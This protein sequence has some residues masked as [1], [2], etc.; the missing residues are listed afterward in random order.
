[1]KTS[2]NE[3][4]K[5]IKELLDTA[6]SAA[7]EAGDIR[8]VWD[9]HTPPS[10]H[11]ERFIN[12]LTARSS[13]ASS[14]KSSQKNRP[15]LI[16]LNKA[17]WMAAASVAIVVSVLFWNQPTLKARDL[18]DVSEKMAQVEEFFRETLAHEVILLEEQKNEKTKVIIERAFD[19]MKKIEADYEKL[20]HDLATSGSDT[21]VI[22]AMIENFQKRI[23]VLEYVITQ[24]EQMDAS[25]SSL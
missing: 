25:T 13:N 15:I 6:R 17:W 19:D 7:C 22:R 12:K 8:S 21:R 20:R 10:G 23:E 5:G 16:H 9:T 4:K 18:G 3:D 1:M 24:I 14:E 11:R 2:D